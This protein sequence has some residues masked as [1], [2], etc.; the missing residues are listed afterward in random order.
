MDAK[1][2]RLQVSLYNSFYLH[3]FIISQW[4]ITSICTQS[5]SLDIAKIFIFSSNIAVEKNVHSTFPFKLKSSYLPM[6]KKCWLQV[7]IYNILDVIYFHQ[8]VQTASS[9]S[10]SSNIGSRRIARP[11]DYDW[12]FFCPLEDLIKI[13]RSTPQ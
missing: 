5:F 4:T 8:N 10:S 6:D 9:T 11:I 2:S 1:V 7:S 13:W 3:I 12:T